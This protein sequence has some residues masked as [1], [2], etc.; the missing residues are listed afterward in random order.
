MSAIMSATLRNGR[1]PYESYVGSIISAGALAVAAGL[2]GGGLALPMV[3]AA[4]GIVAS[5]IGSFC[6]NKGERFAE[7]PAFRAS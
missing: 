6:E 4:L 3:L 7:E 1:G 2:G 5:V